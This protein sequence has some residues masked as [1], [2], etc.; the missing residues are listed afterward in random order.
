MDVRPF[1]DR[2]LVKQVE[3]QELR[4]GGIIIPDP[5]KKMPNTVE[6]G[7]RRRR[8]ARRTRG[9]QCPAFNACCTRWA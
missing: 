8:R 2:I 1:R 9:F 5:A 6:V 3:E 7:V 4:F